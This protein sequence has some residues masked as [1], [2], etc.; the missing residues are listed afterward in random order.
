MKRIK[1]LLTAFLACALLTVT[2]SCKNEPDN[3]NSPGGSMSGEGD[4]GELGTNMVATGG[5]RAVS[6]TQGILLGTV[7]F[8]K[9]GDTHTFGV[10][11]MEAVP[12]T[13]GTKPFDYNLYLVDNGQDV[14][15]AQVN[16][17]ADGKFE[18]QLIDLMP[19]TTYY[20]RSYI[21][22][23]STY[24]YA[25][26]KS[27][28]TLDPSSEINLVTGDPEDICALSSVLVGRASIGNVN[29]GLD[30]IEIKNQKYGFIVADDPALSSPETL[31]I[32]YWENWDNTHFDTQVKPDK[33]K[34]VYSLENINSLLQQNMEGLIPGTSYYYRT[35]FIWNGRYFYSPTVKSFTT[36]GPSTFTVGTL[37]PDDIT[38]KTAR[39]RGHI[40]FEKIGTQS[41][42]PGG[43]MISTKYSNR[44]EFV[45]SDK[46][47]QWPS[48][49][50][51]SYIKT[52]VSDVDFDEEISG[53]TPETTYYIC[54]FVQLG[55]E[56]SSVDK[57][58]QTVPGKPIYLYGDVVSFTTPEF[59]G[60]F[61]I[62]NDRTYPWIEGDSYF[63]SSNHYDGSRSILF[64]QVEAEAAGELSFDWSVESEVDSD[65]LKIYYLDG[66]KSFIPSYTYPIE[67]HSGTE[68]GTFKYNTNFA[69]YPARFTIAVEY[70]KDSSGSAG[71][72]RATISNILYK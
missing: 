49:D 58:G 6:Y 3:P 62:S 43:F 71:V 30:Q 39:L 61:N 15:Q 48:Y 52:K 13:D 27:F 16:T 32:E 24:N 50:D 29:N 5:T 63:Y 10:V 69:Y 1:Y 46:L 31:T 17:T 56:K 72:D 51:I 66:I 59:K 9:L 68:S 2:T 35:V 26:V 21:K 22:I 55:N 12:E 54:A 11:Y 20:Y 23:G 18:K 37:K 70:V 36:L 38:G 33:P 4:Y 67:S 45:M 28:S 8:S 57:Y 34:T 41:S 25:E 65:Y 44:S 64:I 19:G 7:D 53:L 60:D 14:I 40:P 42:V 47:N